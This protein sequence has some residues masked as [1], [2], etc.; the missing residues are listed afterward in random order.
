MASI[1]ELFEYALKSVPDA[2]H[3]HVRQGDAEI[4]V[5]RPQRPVAVG[6]IGGG[7]GYAGETAVA[8]LRE[9]AGETVKAPLVGVFYTAPA[10]DAAPFVTV[11]Q[12]VKKGDTLCIIEAM[13]LMNEIESTHDG[14]IARVLAENGAMVEFGQPLFEIAP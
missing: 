10:P 4:T 3:I 9:A 5:M 6:V 11:G 14:V 1:Q 12:R 2:Q 8:H 7:A 13:K